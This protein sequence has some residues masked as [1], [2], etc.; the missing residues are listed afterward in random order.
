MVL[1]IVAKRTIGLILGG[2]FVDNSFDKLNNEFVDKGRSGPKYWI[3]IIVSFIIE[4]AGLIVGIFAIYKQ[5]TASSGPR[6]YLSLLT[7]LGGLFGLQAASWAKAAAGGKHTQLTKVSFIIGIAV[8]A[9][10]CV[11]LYIVMPNIK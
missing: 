3:E 1:L 2:Y 11:I 10:A 7:L 8:A 9:F 5:I 6:G 4:A